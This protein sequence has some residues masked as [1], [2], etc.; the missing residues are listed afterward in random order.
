MRPLTRYV[1]TATL[2]AGIAVAG[3]APAGA[4]QGSAAQG[5]LILTTGSG[6]RV[7]ANPAAGC[8]DVRGGFSAVANETNVRVT[9][10]PGAGCGGGIGRVVAPG[11]TAGIPGASVSVPR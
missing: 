6:D 11:D 5:N 3:A 4:A 10:Y 1:A 9:V 2:A 8:H 7:I